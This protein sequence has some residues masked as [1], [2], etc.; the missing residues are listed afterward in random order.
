[1]SGDDSIGKFRPLSGAVTDTLW[2]MFA[3]GPT[4]DGDL[5]S[6]SGRDDLVQIGFA[7]RGDGWN[8]LTRAGVYKA[9]G[10]GFDRKKEKAQRDRRIPR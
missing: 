4:Q 5:P 7:E 6:K 10:E 9:L 1:M 2:C 8:W 3:L